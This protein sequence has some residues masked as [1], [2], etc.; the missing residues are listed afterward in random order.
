[1]LS[2]DRFK[3]RSTPKISFGSKLQQGI[4]D[5]PG[6]GAYK[7]S[8]NPF[9]N[10]GGLISKHSSRELGGNRLP[11]PGAYNGDYA[12]ARSKAQSFRWG[13]SERFLGGG[14][15]LPGPGDYEVKDALDRQYGKF[16]REK[17]ESMP[18]KTPGPGDYD[19]HS[20][21]S[22]LD[23]SKSGLPV[24]TQKRMD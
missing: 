11:G 24:S 10:V 3:Y 23:K 19:S 15:G 14:D 8:I 16:G 18:A 2:Q 22:M 21:Y 20:Y 17:R 9:S 13:K 12:V 4:N 6:P 1:V 7:I 5:I